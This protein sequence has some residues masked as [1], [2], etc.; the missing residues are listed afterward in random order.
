MTHRRITVRCTGGRLRRIFSAI[1]VH[2][3]KV[4]CQCVVRFEIV[5]AD[6][7]RRRDPAVV[8][9]LAKVLLAKPEQR[10]TV[11]FG[12][13]ADVVVSVRMKVLAVLIEPSFFGVVV[14]TDVDDLRVPVALLARNVVAAFENQNAFARRGQMVS[15]SP[16]SGTR[17]DNNYVVVIA[18]MANPPLAPQKMQRLSLLW[19]SLQHFTASFPAPHKYNSE[20][21]SM[22][23]G[24]AVR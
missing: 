12:V 4:F 11:K 10:R 1:A 14:A 18:H 16:A 15:E 19:W 17:S 20:A 6:R 9:Q 22:A 21:A 3:I 23:R 8:L 13:P 24:G 7:P 5:I 2:V